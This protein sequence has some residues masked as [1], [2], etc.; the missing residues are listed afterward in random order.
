[1]LHGFEAVSLVRNNQL[2]HGPLCGPPAHPFAED[3]SKP[4]GTIPRCLLFKGTFSCFFFFCVSSFSFFFLAGNQRKTNHFGGSPSKAPDTHF[5][6]EM[7]RS[8]RIVGLQVRGCLWG[9]HL[10]TCAKQNF[11]RPYWT[12][13]WI[14]WILARVDAA[15]RSISADR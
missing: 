5:P 14:L 11:K 15:D 9:F 2:E 4:V 10:L 3:I 1:M 12:F 8:S 6:V 13:S 7:I